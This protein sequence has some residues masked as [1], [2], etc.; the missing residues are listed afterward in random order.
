MCN[1]KIGGSNHNST[2]MIAQSK[3]C[4]NVNSVTKQSLDKFSLENIVPGLT[5]VEKLMCS[6]IVSYLMVLTLYPLFWP[7]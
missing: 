2:G 6:S 5:D 3:L 7:Q 1:L 4:D